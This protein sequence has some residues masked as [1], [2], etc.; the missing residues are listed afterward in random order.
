M[1]TFAG[2]KI[3]QSN[4]YLIQAQTCVTINITPYPPS[5]PT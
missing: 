2:Q 4:P 5:S 3:L 1:L